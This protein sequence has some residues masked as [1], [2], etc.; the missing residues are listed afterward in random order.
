VFRSGGFEAD[1][2]AE[3]GLQGADDDLLARTARSEQRVIVTLDTDFGNIKAYPPELYAGIVV[4]RPAAQD[5]ITVTT[6]VRRLLR[7]L[8]DRVPTHE[9]WIV[10]PSRIRYWNRPKTQ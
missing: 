2:V 5:K 3:E 7:T 1:T 8:R 9:L 6:M 10:E 4:L